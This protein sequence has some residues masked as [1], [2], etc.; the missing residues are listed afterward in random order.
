MNKSQE[1]LNSLIA[2]REPLQERSAEL[3]AKSARVAA[4]REVEQRKVADAEKANQQ[5]AEKIAAAIDAGETEMPRPTSA[6]RAAIEAAAQTAP[7]LRSLDQK[8]EMIRGEMEELDAESRDLEERIATE[9]ARAIGDLLEKN[10]A[11]RREAQDTLDTLGGVEV[12]LQQALYALSPAV[13]GEIAKRI[14]E[15]R[16]EWARTRADNVNAQS[17]ARAAE[18][19]GSIPA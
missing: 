16:A 2:K 18:L 15:S 8:A 3:A 10:H 1:Q 4:A 7:I 11:A 9:R 17:G 12:A 5:L 14:E 13:A 19:L 6:Q